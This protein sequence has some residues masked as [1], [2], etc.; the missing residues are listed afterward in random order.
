M[1]QDLVGSEFMKN[2]LGFIVLGLL[3][4]GCVAVGNQTL[5][6]ENKNIL[7]PNNDTISNLEKYYRNNKKFNLG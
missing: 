1:V 3:L 6:V 4:F 5:E 7:R 2:I